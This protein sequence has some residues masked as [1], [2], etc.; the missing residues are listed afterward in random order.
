MTNPLTRPTTDFPPPPVTTTP[1][2]VPITSWADMHRETAITGVQ[3]DLFWYDL[4]QEGVA[5]FFSWSGEP[6]ATV[7]VVWD[8]S[9]TTHIECCKAGDVPATATECLP[10]IA[11]VTQVFRKAG[12]W[13]EIA[14]H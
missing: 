6:R 8:I 10:I 9:G 1:L 12:F 3:F 13:A 14:N 2:L 4:V 11:E 5:Y 7:L